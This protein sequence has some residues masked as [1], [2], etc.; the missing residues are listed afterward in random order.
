MPNDVVLF[1][2][3][4]PQNALAYFLIS[5]TQGFVAGPAG[6]AG[7]LC[8]GGDI[9]RFVGFGQILNTGTGGAVSLPI[10]LTRLPQPTMN[11]A[12][13]PGDTWN[14]TCWFRDAIGGSPTSNF[15]DGLRIDFL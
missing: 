8:L 4:M 11:V 3:D 2:S 5:R 15:T 6:S 7:N 1:A 14:F 12:A 9:G 10:D 13:M